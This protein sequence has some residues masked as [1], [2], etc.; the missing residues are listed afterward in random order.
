MILE[1]DAHSRLRHHSLTTLFLAP[2]RADAHTGYTPVLDRLEPAADR[3][4]SFQRPFFFI[5]DKPDRSSIC[6]PIFVL[7]DPPRLDATVTPPIQ[8]LLSVEVPRPSSESWCCCTSLA[9]IVTPL[10]WPG[11]AG[12]TEWLDGYTV[13]TRTANTAAMVRAARRHCSTSSPEGKQ[14][15]SPGWEPVKLN[16]PC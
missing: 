3:L 9:R 12:A 16:A 2:K 10:R 15:P 1:H 13:L 7:C 8:C 4:I 6:R 14:L 11:T 5:F